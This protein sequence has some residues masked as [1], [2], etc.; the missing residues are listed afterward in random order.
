MKE[1]RKRFTENQIEKYNKRKEEFNQFKNIV[2]KIV[3]P[4][5]SQC[6]SIYIVE[7][8]VKTLSSFVEKFTRQTHYKNPIDQITDI[9]GIRVIFPIVDNVERLSESIKR[10]FTIDARLSGERTKFLKTSEFGYRSTHYS[11]KLKQH[12]SLYK[13]L[14]LHIPENM[15]DLK[16]EIQIRT[17]LEHAWATIYH[18]IGYKSQFK[19]PEELDRHLHRLSATLE[20]VD[21]SLSELYTSLKR[22]ESNFDAYLSK[23]QI[24]NEIERLDLILK[25]DPTNPSIL[26]K[27]TNMAK[28]IGNWNIIIEIA[29]SLTEGKKLTE[30]RKLTETNKLKESVND[31]IILKNA[32]IAYIKSNEYGHENYKTGIDYLKKSIEIDNTDIDA[33]ASLGGAYKGHDEAKAKKYYE[34]AF[35]AEPDHPYSLGNFLIYELKEKG[36]MHPILLTKSIIQKAIERS[37]R[38]LTMNINI[39]WAYY[40]L[41]LFYLFLNQFNKSVYNF[42]LGIKY[43][44]DKRMIFTTYKT[45]EILRDMDT[46]L[47]GIKTIKELLLLSLA[48]NYND[49]NSINLLN[50]EY[51][52]EINRLSSPIIVIAGTSDP[53][54]KG[55]IKQIK[56]NLMKAF[57]NF[58]GTLISGGTSSGISKLTAELQK[59]YPEKIETIGYLPEGKK[60]MVEE[61][62]QRIC[63]TSNSD[64]SLREAMRYWWDI[65]ANGIDQHEVKLIGIGGGRISRLEYRLALLFGAVIGLFKDTGGQAD[66]LIQDEHWKDFQK[67]RYPNFHVLTNDVN[68]IKKFF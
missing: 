46:K 13:E 6:S 43:S 63:I 67:G 12:N 54:L 2:L 9:V 40:N 62:Y 58:K 68:E 17:F 60:N 35:E 66:T 27:I 26:R 61:L 52:Y 36:N 32:G 11:I 48:F 8:R 64:F 19:V 47:N 5:A 39:P 18:G 59:H 65:F 10:N 14:D 31:P 44:T 57:K 16:A 21:T 34:M 41:G 51:N 38:H 42:I 45:L 56:P 22:Y 29:N 3:D 37:N 33:L 20:G 30:G 1:K 55:K 53:N 50:K 24:E 15:Y 25:S 23:E 7:N 4:L 28:S 49:E